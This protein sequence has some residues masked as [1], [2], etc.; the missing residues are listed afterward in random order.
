M[1]KYDRRTGQVQDV[2][3]E[4]LR[5][6]KYRFLRTAPLVFSTIDKKSLY[7][8]ANVLFRTRTRGA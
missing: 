4:A 1:Q 6:G 3:P 8:A 7:L 2:A 5:S